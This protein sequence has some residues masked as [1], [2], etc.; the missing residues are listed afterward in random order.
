MTGCQWQF[1]IAL[2][3]LTLILVVVAFGLGLARAEGRCTVDTVGWSSEF[4]Y[5]VS[6]IDVILSTGNDQFLPSVHGKF[7][8]TS[9][10]AEAFID[11]YT[12]G[13]SYPCQY[14]P[15]FPNRVVLASGKI[16]AG[17]VFWG[18]I[19]LALL[20]GG[21]GL[22]N[23][24]SIITSRVTPPGQYQPIRLRPEGGTPGT[25]LWFS[26][27]MLI[28][29]SG[30]I[31]A[32]VMV[33]RVLL[34]I[35]E[36]ADLFVA[37]AVLL[38]LLSSAASV[39]LLYW[40]AR[41]LYLLY[42]KSETIVEIST[43]PLRPGQTA[44]LYVSHWPGRVTVQ[45]LQVKLICE[46]TIRKRKSTGRADASYSY[47]SQVI[48]EAIIYEQTDFH[49][50]STSLWQQTMDLVTPPEA[51]SSREGHYPEIRWWVA[52]RV[53]VASA[54]DFEIEFPVKVKK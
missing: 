38:L 51:R 19:A 52:V 44:Q 10:E 13:Q 32:L 1:T 21:F 37:A 30:V 29:L 22:A 42:T 50:Y 46:E 25:H 17:H 54:P 47:E 4:F 7:H 3:L 14:N 20:F 34:I 43:Q 48:Y 23:M 33:I 35:E 40:T 8:P 49:L 28:A 41:Q 12:I 26:L 5:T 11:Q 36:K 6:K 2:F 9:T 15:R 27:P 16:P 24:L 39:G 31:F 45:Q 53:A 18:L